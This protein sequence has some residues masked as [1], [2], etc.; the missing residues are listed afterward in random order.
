MSNS[1]A[2]EQRY[3]EG[4]IRSAEAGQFIAEISD[5]IT[6]ALVN[7]AHF[8]LFRR[9]AEKRFPKG[10]FDMRFFV[11]VMA[12]MFSNQDVVRRI[13]DG[14]HVGEFFEDEP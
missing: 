5:P 12:E 8:H 1:S 10:S 2:D 7:N 9:L 6:K 14:E 13:L 4:F 11:E 3:P